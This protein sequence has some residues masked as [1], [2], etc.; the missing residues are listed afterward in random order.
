[1]AELTDK[2]IQVIEALVEGM[3]QRDAAKAAHVNECTVSSWRN[4]DAAFV[5]ELNT[6]RKY[7]WDAK[8]NELRGLAGGAIKTLADLHKHG[9]SDAI[10]LKAAVAILDRGGLADVGAAGI[11]PT[12]SEEVEKNWRQLNIIEELTA[13]G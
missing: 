6:R 9:D 12:T 11:G 4:S 10:R 8:V 2:Q 7:I 1:M 5:A 3:T 13:W